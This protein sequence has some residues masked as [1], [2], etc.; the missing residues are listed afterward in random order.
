MFDKLMLII[1]GKIE[2]NKI[3]RS[4]LN[5]I[6]A[7]SIIYTDLFK[8]YFQKALPFYPLC[9]GEEG[10]RGEDLPAAEEPLAGD[11]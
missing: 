8:K 6:S 5:I 1:H 4:P 3:T 2:Y 7:L 10:T 11:D 9:L